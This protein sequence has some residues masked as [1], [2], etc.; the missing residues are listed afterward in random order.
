FV[1]APLLGNRDLHIVGTL[2]SIVRGEIGPNPGI[3]PYFAPFGAPLR[4][5]IAHPGRATR[6]AGTKVVSGPD[7]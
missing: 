2:G 4:I 5:C 6:P 1:R 3:W 7:I